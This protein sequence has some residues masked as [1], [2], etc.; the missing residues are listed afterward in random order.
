MAEAFKLVFN[1]SLVLSLSEH[2]NKLDKQPGFSFKAKEFRFAAQN[3]L[4]RL[5]LKARSKHIQKALD[6]HI[7]CDLASLCRY[8]PTL[9]HP[10][11][12]SS[13]STERC[14]Q[15]GLAGW[16]L[17]PV[18]DLLAQRLLDLAARR[19][20]SEE[21]VLAVLQCMRAM[22][23]R[24]S[25]EFCVR[26]LI[27]RFPKLSL[28]YLQQTA[29]SVND[30]ERRWASEGTRP[31]LPW[32]MSLPRLGKDPSIALPILEQLFLDPA[33]YVR[34]SVA[35]HLN[36]YS[37]QH[38]DFVHSTAQAW[39]KQYQRLQSKTD[40]D[41]KA[42]RSMLKKACRNNIKNGHQQTLALFG[43]TPAKVDLHVSFPKSV[44]RDASALLEIA[45]T[46]LSKARQNLVVDY[47]IGYQRANGS[48]SYKVFKG[49]ELSL[50]KGES[51]SF[52]K[53]VSF[54]PITTRKYYLGLHDIRIK[55]NGEIQASQPFTLIN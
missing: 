21:L 23:S 37:H 32:G 52:A 20:V 36:D 13:I 16:A 17:M 43:V 53:K 3:G 39:Q 14:S 31:K 27:E 7:E 10:D 49:K 22:T 12:R 54:K 51:L 48:L 6:E 42:F 24:F 30:H 18:G 44:Q 5:E 25:A 19:D 38:P 50:E 15:Q 46:S 29:T 33:I 47:E 45:V 2:F 40:L 4:E 34:T 1:D 55:V 28:S 9:L 41:P 26:P 8:I 35:N 11:D